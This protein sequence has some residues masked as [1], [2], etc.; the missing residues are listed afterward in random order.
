MSNNDKEKNKVMGLVATAKE[1]KFFSLEKEDLTSDEGKPLSE[2]KIDD[3]NLE[4][5]S[6][7]S[8]KIPANTLIVPIYNKDINILLSNTCWKRDYNSIELPTITVH[9]KQE[10]VETTLRKACWLHLKIGQLHSEQKSK[11]HKQDNKEIAFL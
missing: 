1:Y 8:Y 10:E 7:N 4:K 9:G 3:S 5:N 6:D 2:W 11:K